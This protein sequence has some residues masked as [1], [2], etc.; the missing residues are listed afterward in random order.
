MREPQFVEQVA[1]QL[2]PSSVSVAERAIDAT[3]WAFAEGIPRRV[4]H[5]IADRLPDR[6]G[7][8]LRCAE[9]RGV[10]DRASLYARVHVLE[11][12]DTRVARDHVHAVCTVL[13][14]L[15]P[16][17][18]VRLLAGN[19]PADV[20]ALLTEPEGALE[21]GGEALA[22]REKSRSESRR[23]GAPVGR[24]LAAG[25]PAHRN[26][27]AARAQAAPTG[28]I[29]AQKNPRESTKLASARGQT[30]E[31][32]HRTLAEAR[33]PIAREASLPTGKVRD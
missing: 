3:L 5:R 10:P 24:T 14:R 18:A 23:I 7:A 1:G 29:L 11:D 19:Q 33:P 22:H 32:H 16:P 25:R 6:F 28:S 2:G 13:S 4:A 30:A 27:V 31:R 20:A 26:S 8:A 17:F 21:P 15:L 12:V 9:F